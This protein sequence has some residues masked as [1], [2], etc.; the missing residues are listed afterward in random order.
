M[1]RS[2]GADCYVRARV[3]FV[4]AAIAGLYESLLRRPVAPGNDVV[5]VIERDIHRT[6]PLHAMF[7]DPGGIGQR[8]LLRVLRAY[9]QYDQRVC[10][11]PVVFGR[12]ACVVFCIVWFVSVC[13]RI[14]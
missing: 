5:E 2:A 6:F 12:S 10:F 9:A 11:S 4:A 8:S 13:A 1:R 14:R 7:T 3:L